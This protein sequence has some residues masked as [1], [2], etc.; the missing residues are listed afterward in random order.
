MFNWRIINALTPLK[1]SGLPNL[2]AQKRIV[3]ELL[4]DDLTPDKLTELTLDLLRNPEKCDAQRD[5]LD[6]VYQQLGESGA[7]ERTAQLVLEQV[8]STHNSI[9]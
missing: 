1:H 4:Q 7:A 8:A 5:A 9:Q 6:A 2:I 3:P